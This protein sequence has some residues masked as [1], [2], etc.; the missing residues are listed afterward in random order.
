[1]GPPHFA[2]C[3]YLSRGTRG[4]I[5]VN[6]FD[7]L[8]SFEAYEAIWH[9]PVEN[10]SPKVVCILYDT[11][12]LRILEGPNARPDLFLRTAGLMTLRADRIVCISLSAERDVAAFFPASRGKTTVIHIAHHAERFRDRGPPGLADAGAVRRILMVG[13]IDRRK[14]LHNVYL[15]LPL[16]KR[17]MGDARLE[18]LIVGNDG[19]RQHFASLEQEAM[20]HADLRWTGYVS[21]DELPELYRSADVF[22][23]PSLWEGFGIPVLEAMSSGVP[24]VCSDLSSLPEVGG[25]CAVYC[26]PYEPSSIADAIHAVLTMTPAARETAIAKGREW[27]DTFTWNRAG[28]QMIDLIKEISLANPKSV[29]TPSDNS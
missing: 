3:R 11:I 4:L 29:D 7:V 8:I 21:D 28:T 5:S 27:A 26:D 13:D 14:N 20:K 23:F 1:M 18:L 22:V 17:R 25:N 12:P 6:R 9:W 16:L 15:A 10:I 24:V 2:A 19:Q